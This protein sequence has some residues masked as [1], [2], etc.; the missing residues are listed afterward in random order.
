LNGD[1]VR[2]PLG[3]IAF[4]PESKE[5]RERSAPSRAIP[6][7]ES[8]LRSHPCVAVPS[9][10]VSPHYQL[11]ANSLLQVLRQRVCRTSEL[12]FVPPRPVEN[13]FVESF[14]GRLR[15]ECL[16]AGQ[17]VHEVSHEP[18][19]AKLRSHARSAQLIVAAK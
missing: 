9:A 6:A 17:P 15:D 19:P 12:C 16:N 11:H 2:K 8:A 18:T 10:Q 5:A 1:S 7:A 4:T 13:G 3:F 14:T